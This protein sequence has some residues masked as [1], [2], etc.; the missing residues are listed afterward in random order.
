MRRPKIRGLTSL[1]ATSMLLISALTGC[2]HQPATILG[3]NTVQMI[4]Q[5]ESQAV[6]G[7]KYC[8][9]P[10]TLARLLE[11]AEACSGKKP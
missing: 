8:L 9:G 4:S 10:E 1:L 11:R 5:G 3:D 6:Q 2:Y 7:L